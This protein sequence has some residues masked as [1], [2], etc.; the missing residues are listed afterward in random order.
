MEKFPPLPISPWMDCHGAP[1]TVQGDLHVCSPSRS[2]GTTQSGPVPGGGLC[3]LWPLPCG[4]RSQRCP[5]GNGEGGRP[6]PPL[7]CAT[8]ANF[9]KTRRRPRPRPGTVGGGRGGGAGAPGPVAP[10][11]PA[12]A[13]AAHL[14]PAGRRCS[15]NAPQPGLGP[16]PAQLAPRRDSRSSDG[17]HGAPDPARYAR[18]R[19]PRWRG[20]P[21]TPRVAAAAEPGCKPEPGCPSLI[22]GAAPLRGRGDPAWFSWP[23]PCA[24]CLCYSRRSL[25]SEPEWGIG[26]SPG[27][28]LQGGRRARVSRVSSYSPH[29][30]PPHVLLL[31]GVPTRAGLHPARVSAQLGALQ[32]P[33][34]PLLRSAPPPSYKRPRISQTGERPRWA[35]GVGRACGG[36]G[37]HASLKI[38]SDCGTGQRAEAVTACLQRSVFLRKGTP[39]LHKLKLRTGEM[40]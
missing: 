30:P 5:R 1:V 6:A 39:I 7:Q 11:P 27:R 9:Q 34:E 40:T 33:S 28:S 22:P 2:P 17:Q 35:R 10:P 23:W 36:R 14:P 8:G 12:A 16:R 37:R 32:A 21:G 18:S 31:G 15:G 4:R 3:A 26:A 13:R 38:P 24:P 29:A 25:M 20:A 19:A